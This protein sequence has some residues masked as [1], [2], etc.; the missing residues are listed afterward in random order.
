MT[1]MT[2]EEQRAA[3]A[4]SY[5][6][7]TAYD[8]AQATQAQPDSESPYEEVG[9]P[10]RGRRRSSGVPRAPRSDAG[11]PRGP[12]GARVPRQR[13]PLPALFGAAWGMLGYGLPWL[14]PDPPATAMSRAMQLQTPMAGPILTDA[15]KRTPVYPLIKPMLDS[16]GPWQE[17]AQLIAMPIT[18]GIVAMRPQVLASP[19]VQQMVMAQLM[20]TIIA[21]KKRHKEVQDT[22]GELAQVDEQTMKEAQ[23]AMSWLFGAPPKEEEP[24]P[25]PSTEFQP[26]VVENGDSTE[27]S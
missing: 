24:E 3:L 14:A 26:E 25:E 5:D 22:L 2:Q 4:D 7:T 8:Q 11:K 6:A 13:D 20:P 21:A 12:R 23:Q 9:V 18:V 16:V 17:L 1:T 15:F 27:A 10:Q 19:M